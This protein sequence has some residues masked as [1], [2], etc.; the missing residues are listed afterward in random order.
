MISLLTT[1]TA[2]Q[3][4]QNKQIVFISEKCFGRLKFSNLIL[5]SIAKKYSLSMQNKH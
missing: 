3:F 2:K 4:K 5:A 1:K